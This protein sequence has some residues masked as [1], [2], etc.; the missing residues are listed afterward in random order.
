[1]TH[2]D[3][4]GPWLVP[5][6]VGFAAAGAGLGAGW[7]LRG[8]PSVEDASARPVEVQAG[9]GVTRD[10]LE[11]MKREILAR[12]EQL[13][14]A[15]SSGSPLAAA[16]PA[17]ETVIE[18]GRRLDDLDARIAVLSTGVRPGIGGRAWANL[19]GRGSESIEKISTRIQEQNRRAQRNE[20]G[21][22]VPAAVLQEHNFW[23]VEDVVH[24]Y[25]PPGRIT[26]TDGL[27]FYY[28]RFSLEHVDEPCFVYFRFREGFLVE[29][30]YDCVSGW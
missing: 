28:G 17:D 21:E 13:G 4:R 26:G 14:R 5:L 7:F 16:Q 8:P 9:S 15:R 24:A 6:L 25:G 10:E 11:S 29:V 27:T 3:A 18:L 2:D 19:R 20:P 1:M 12:L 22:D 30:G 23:T